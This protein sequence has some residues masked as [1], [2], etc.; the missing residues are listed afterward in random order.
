MYHLPLFA[1]VCTVGQAQAINSRIEGT[2]ENTAPTDTLI[3]IDAERHKKI[4]E[5]HV[6]DGIIIPASGTLEEATVCCIAKTGRRGWISW[7]L[8]EEGTVNIGVDLSVDYLR[9]VSGTPMNGEL[10]GVLALQFRKYE[11]NDWYSHRQ[12]RST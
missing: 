10:A 1:L 5:L 11:H 3:V 7:F 9:H 4:A 12:K 6:K 2:V 8:L